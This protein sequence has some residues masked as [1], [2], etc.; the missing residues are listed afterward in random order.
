MD[1]D[2]PL[3]KQVGGDHYKD[4]KIQPIEYIMANDLPY[5]EANI[6]KYIT[7]WRKK[8]GKEDIKKVIHYAEILLN[9]VDKT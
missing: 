2:D 6:V 4:C 7:R 9:S 5:C 3:K 8:G 1:N